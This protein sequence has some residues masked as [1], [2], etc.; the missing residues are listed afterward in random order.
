MTGVR[1][2]L[3]RPAAIRARLAEC[4][5]AFIGLGTLEWHSEHAPVGLD[6]LSVERLCELAADRAGGFAFPTLWYGEPRSVSHMDT[7][8][9]DTPAIRDALGMVP[10]SEVDLGDPA[11]AIA[12]YRVL[13]RDLVLQV[14]SAGM[15]VVCL[16]CGHT[17]MFGWLARVVEAVN[18]STAGRAMTLLGTPYHYVIDPDAGLNPGSADHAGAWETSYLWHLMPGSIDLSVYPD[19][20]E[21]RLIGVLG[22]DPRR[23]ASEERGAAATERTVAGMVAQTRA[24]LA[25]LREATDL[26]GSPL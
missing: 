11:E 8:E 9:E 18:A 5:I 1:Y 12:R 26:E 23:G 16:V 2:E 21:S 14:Q 7:T 10:L 3:M 15:K 24:A 20:D 6:G 13:V 17:P 4:P 19:G 25:H 22:E